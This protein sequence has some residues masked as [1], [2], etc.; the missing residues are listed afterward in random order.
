MLVEGHL[1]AY[2]VYRLL[3][4]QQTAHFLLA[5][6]PWNAYAYVIFRENLNN[7]NTRFTN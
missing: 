2:S 7:T 5:T 1:A 3:S 4:V 6:A